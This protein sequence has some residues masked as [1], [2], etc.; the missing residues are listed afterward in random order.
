VSPGDTEAPTAAGTPTIMSQEGLSATVQW[1]AS[2]SRDTAGYNYDIRTAAG[3]GGSLIKAGTVNGLTL[4]IT[5]PSFGTFYVRVEPIDHTGNHGPI[6]AALEIVFVKL[7]GSTGIAPG[8]VTNPELGP[9]AVETPNVAAGAISGNTPLVD[10][11]THTV[12]TSESTIGSFTLAT[13]GG[14][15]AIHFKVTLTG[16]L[17]SPNAVNVIVRLRKGTASGTILDRALI[18]PIAPNDGVCLAIDAS[19]AASQDY[20]ITALH[21]GSTGSY[22]L[23]NI[24]VVAINMKK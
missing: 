6:T 7:V 13:S 3:G 24:R 20:T 9:G 21:D 23:G 5:A 14:Y 4:P 18:F 11:T 19:P 15:A 17:S 1:T 2:A 12:T 16:L 22:V 8:T 10:D